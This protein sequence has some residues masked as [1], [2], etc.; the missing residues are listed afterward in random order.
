VWWCTTGFLTFLPIHAAGIYGE[1]ALPESKLSDFVVSSYIPTLS[2]LITGSCPATKPN[3]QVLAVALP[4]E[5]HLP[6]TGQELDCIANRVGSS[7]VKKLVESE[8]TLENVI[9]GLKDSSFIHFACHGVQD[10]ESP[11]ESALILANSSRLTLSH[12]HH[13]SF[14]HA[15]LAFLSACQ[16][17]TGD[18]RLVQEAVHLAAGMLS[19]GYRGVIATMWSI[20][21]SDA[22]LVA[23]EIYAHLFKNS[24]PDPTQAS[25]ALHNAIKK[26]IKDSNGEKSFF[27]WVPFIHI[28]I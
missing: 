12:L 20:M 19:A 27:E 26:L 9:A 17:A 1:K 15:Q 8:A 23:D 6:N 5:S 3:C 7:N 10:A 2:S 13:L 11:N 24:K 22:P 4:V 28:G 18:E 16:T 25:R 14:P 21:D